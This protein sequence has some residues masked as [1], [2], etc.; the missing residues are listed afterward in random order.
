[1]YVKRN[2]CTG[3]RELVDFFPASLSSI[4]S[5]LEAE[6]TRG[7]W[8]PV[9]MNG[10]DWPSPAANLLAIEAEIRDML[11]ALGITT[12]NSSTGENLP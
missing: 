6:V 2:V 11:A 8:K 3:L 12:Q 4:S 5:Y 10:K 9:P 7:L 1:L